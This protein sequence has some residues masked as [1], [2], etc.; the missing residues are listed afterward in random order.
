MS[1]HVLFNLLD[2]FE[3]IIKMRILSIILS[4]FGNK[5]DKFNNVRF[6]LS[7]DPKTFLLIGN[8]ERKSDVHSLIF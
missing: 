1:S 3:K 6:F 4:L 5:F 8:V 2:E 7:Y